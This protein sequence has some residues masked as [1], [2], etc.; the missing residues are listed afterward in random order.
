MMSL[1][2]VQSFYWAVRQ[3]ALMWLLPS[4]V[5]RLQQPQPSSSHCWF[6]QPHHRPQ[7]HSSPN[8]Q[9]PSGSLAEFP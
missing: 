1:P 2:K 6:T 7:A 3:D 9:G 8:F 5:L 4:W